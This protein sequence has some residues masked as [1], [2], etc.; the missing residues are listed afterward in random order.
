MSWVR[1]AV[2][3]SSSLHTRRA[4]R[5]S[6]SLRKLIHIGPDRVSEFSRHGRDRRHPSRCQ[7]EQQ[8]DTHAPVRLRRC[9][10]AKRARAAASASCC[11]CLCDTA[12]ASESESP[13]TS[14]LPA[15]GLSMLRPPLRAAGVPSPRTCQPGAGRAGGGFL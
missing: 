2:V 1:R 12:L 7:V 15:P 11:C 14:K 4:H 6:M 10:A 8:A 3:S 9:M 5:A 13:T